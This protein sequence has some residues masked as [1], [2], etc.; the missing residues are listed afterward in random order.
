[1]KNIIFQKFEFFLTEIKKYHIFRSK[2]TSKSNQK[3]KKSPN[4]SGSQ[5]KSKEEITF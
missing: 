3:N 5:S 2:L 4:F 1:M